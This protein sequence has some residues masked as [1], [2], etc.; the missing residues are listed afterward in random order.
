MLIDYPYITLT[1]AGCIIFFAFFIRSLTG[2]GGA[3]ISVPLL[4]LLF[5]LK[6]AVPFEAIFDIGI[7]LILIGSVYRQ[8]NKT[9]LVP[10]LLGAMIGTAIGSAMLN[11]M[12]D[13]VL[14]HLLGVSII[15]FALNLLRRPADSNRPLAGYWG[16]LAGGI[17]GFFGGLFGTS[18]PPFVI[19][20]SYKIKSK[21]TLRASLIGLFAFDGLWR[22]GLF[23]YTGLITREMMTLALLF[24]PA[25]C[26]GAMLGN[27]IHTRIDE[28]RFRQLVAGILVISGSL[29]LIH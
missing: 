16:G 15:L 6:F 25:L 27:H 29:L 11:L 8:I 23:A 4:A 20:L 2:F 1:L 26:L 19:Y 13:G 21:D 28:A 5:D 7:S 9:T 18:G 14:K 10:L 24:T 22:F 12:A 17:G 3:L